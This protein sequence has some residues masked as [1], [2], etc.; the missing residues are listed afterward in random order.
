MSKEKQSMVKA[1]RIAGYEYNDFDSYYAPLNSVETDFVV[2][3]NP[4]GRMMFESWTEVYEWLCG[5][6]FDDPDISDA[7][8]QAI[9]NI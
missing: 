6:V 1:M 7:V 8:E 2:F 5:V 3:D 4:Y 9:A